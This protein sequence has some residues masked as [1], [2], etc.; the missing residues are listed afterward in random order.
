MRAA[1][2][3]RG[4]TAL[5]ALAGI[6]LLLIHTG[7]DPASLIYFTVQSN[8][9]V[10]V[11]FAL[12]ALGRVPVSIRGAATL[13]IVIT[14]TVY[15]LVLTNPGS[16]FFTVDP[17]AHT[18]HNFLLHTLTPLLAAVDWLLL[19]RDK[20]PWWYA[21]SWLAYPLAYLAFALIR[22]AVVHKYPYPFLDAGELGYLGV[23]ISSLVFAVLF[24]LLGLAL[25]GLGGLARRFRPGAVEPAGA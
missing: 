2:S 3:F 21:G 4:L 11:V 6:V 16:P 22:G 15:H 14:G 8:A 5:S 20:T 13:Y 25:I 18:V 10:A 24:F 1:A 12:A 9:L 23:T 17:G 19:N 7:G